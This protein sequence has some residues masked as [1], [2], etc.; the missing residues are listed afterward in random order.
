MTGPVQGHNALSRL[1][2]ELVEDDYRHVPEVDQWRRWTETGWADGD[3]QAFLSM[4]KVAES[5]WRDRKGKPDP[6]TAGSAATANG[7]LRFAAAR[8]R[9]PLEEWDADPN[10][11]GIGGG[12][13][14]DLREGE[15]RPA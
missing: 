7:G 15:C 2:G 1:W 8:R 13:V 11:L 6:V 12:N 10:L 3:D 9:K 4:S 5:A 14:L